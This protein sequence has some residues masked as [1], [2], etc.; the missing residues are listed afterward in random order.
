MSK[1][2]VDQILSVLDFLIEDEIELFGLDATV[3]KLL[4]SGVTPEELIDVFKF[5]QE[6]IDRIIDENEEG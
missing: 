4:D 1:M 5:S 3:L 2:T 6:D